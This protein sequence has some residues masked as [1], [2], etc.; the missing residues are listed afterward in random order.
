MQGVFYA[1]H[2]KDLLFADDIAIMLSDPVDMQ[3]ALDVLGKY[4]WDWHLTISLSKTQAM[5]INLPANSPPVNFKV[6]DNTLE[7]VSNTDTLEFGFLT[8]EDGR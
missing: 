1:Q 2:L 8:M 3:C 7:V 4:C 6:G 5:V